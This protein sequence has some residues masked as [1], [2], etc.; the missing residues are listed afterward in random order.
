MKMEQYQMIGKLIGYV[1]TEANI[2][3]DKLCRG[4]C[5][6]T[7]L[8]RVENGKRECEQILSEAL[9]QRAGVASDRF[10]FTAN[11][12]EQIW[13]T[14]REKMY[15]AVDVGDNEKANIAFE[16][17]QKISERNGK[18]RI[19]SNVIRSMGDFTTRNFFGG[20]Q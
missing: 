7:F 16:E 15:R 6:R 11:P 1:R 9:L 13:I 8:A 17:Y 5:S 4:L 19:I 2:S 12:E 10:V 14:C 20:N 18:E 3:P